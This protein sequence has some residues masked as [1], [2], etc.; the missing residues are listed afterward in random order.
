M[1]QLLINSAKEVQL[2]KTYKYNLGGQHFEGNYIITQSKVSRESR[3]ILATLRAWASFEWR[4]N[5]KWIDKRVET[6][7]PLKPSRFR[8]LLVKWVECRPWSLVK[9][10]KFSAVQKLISLLLA[11]VGSE[12]RLGQHL[13][14]N[15]T[16]MA[17]SSVF[18]E[19]NRHCQMQNRT[20]L[21]KA[22]ACIKA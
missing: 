14:S 11:I 20:H 8:D 21:D 13:K 12:L 7:S 15:F 10:V 17:S 19:I 3:E 9:S 18:D 1:L 5:I 22:T 2:L 4:S 16:T 6:H